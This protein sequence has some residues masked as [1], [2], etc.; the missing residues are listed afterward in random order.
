MAP[1]DEDDK[2]TVVLDLNALKK[3]KLAEE[4][5]LAHIEE[6]IEFD[7]HTHEQ[8][9][10]TITSVASMP[11]REQIRV[12]LFDFQSDFFQKSM[13]FF[14]MGFD[15]VMAT[16]LDELNSCLRSKGFQIVVFNYD[17]NPKAMNQLSAQ[18]KQKFP[19]SKVLIVARAISPEKAKL[20]A[21]TPSGASGYFQLPLDPKRL[22]DELVRIHEKEK[23]SA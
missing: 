6:E 4:E 3:Q 17:V 15:Y 2:P 5:K 8:S 23:K 9:E 19:E 12:V 1:G 7:V 11:E 14:P 22:E 10:D 20:H 21:K 16:T 13:K 18:I